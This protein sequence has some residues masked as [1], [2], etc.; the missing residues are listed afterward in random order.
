MKTITLEAML[1]GE[2]KSEVWRK[3]D[4]VP[5]VVYGRKVPATSIAVPMKAFVKALREAGET[6]VLAISAGET[7]FNALIRD[8]DR[9]P[10][11]GVPI[12]VDFYAIVMDEEVE[13]SVAI[14]F[15]GEALA[16]KSEGG[17]LVKSLDEVSV[18]ALPGDLPHSLIAD[19]SKLVS[20]EDVIHVKDLAVSEKVAVLADPETIVASVSRPREEEESLM[21]AAP[22]V[23]KIEVAEK[24]KKE[25]SEEETA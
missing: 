7:T 5:A 18:R 3:E 4:Y 22:D 17:V 11:S 9:H 23:S 20:F 10:I 2:K 16:V 1:R 19:V 25:S 12:H 24:G 13:A 8:V 21:D 6:T 15:V 14:E